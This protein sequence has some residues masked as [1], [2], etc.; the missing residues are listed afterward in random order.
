MYKKI[1]DYLSGELNWLKILRL[2]WQI[3]KSDEMRKSFIEY[4]GMWD[5]LRVWREDIEIPEIAVT[6]R[7]GHPLR[8]KPAF[9]FIPAIIGIGIGFY[10]GLNSYIS[11]S[12]YMNYAV[13]V[14]Y[15]E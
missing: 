12:D 14:L 9:L 13:E 6:R 3:K 7:V 10:L 8:I 4:K 15:E 1:I 11:A 5:E 2:K